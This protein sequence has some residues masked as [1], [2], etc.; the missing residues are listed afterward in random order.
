MTK[1]T[2]LAL[3]EMRELGWK[4]V[5]PTDT[6]SRVRRGID[7]LMLYANEECQCEERTCLR[8]LN[9]IV[10]VE[11]LYQRKKPSV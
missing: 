5:P 11:M 6:V 3:D 1:Y 9:I 8:C 10:T 2:G 7:E 4:D